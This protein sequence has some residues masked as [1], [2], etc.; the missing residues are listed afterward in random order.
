MPG[1]TETDMQYVHKYSYVYIRHTTERNERPNKAQRKGNFQ[2]LWNNGSGQHRI[3]G[4]E[5]KKK[6]EYLKR[7]RKLLETKL[8]SM[9]FKKGINIWAVP[10]GRYSGLFFKW[11]KAE[12]KQ[13]DQRTR[14]L[15]TIHKALHPIDNDDRCQEKK[16]GE[17][18]DLPSL[19]IAL[20]HRYSD[21]KTT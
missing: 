8:Y 15:M 10:F 16:E 7:T 3:N 13:M 18:E 12:L 1:N 9:N 17:G 21:S 14:K 4:A 5:R 19:R 11:T 6:K 2:I 20:I